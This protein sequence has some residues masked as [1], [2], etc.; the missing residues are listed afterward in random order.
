MLWLSDRVIRSY[1]GEWQDGKM[2]GY[3]EMTYADQSVYVG[4]WHLNK[5]SGHGRMEYHSTGSVYTGGWES[6]LRS[7]YGVYDNALKYILYYSICI[8]HTKTRS[9]CTHVLQT[10]G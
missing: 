2:E 4:W 8:D 10:S 9:S 6:D 3:G 5:R 1:T 7:G